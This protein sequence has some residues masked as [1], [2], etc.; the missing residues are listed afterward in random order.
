MFFNY[1]STTNLGDPTI[2][3][4][5]AYFQPTIYTGNGEFKISNYSNVVGIQIQITGD[6]E[7][8]ENYLKD[9][10]ELYYNNNVSFCFVWFLTCFMFSFFHVLY[11]ALFVYILFKKSSFV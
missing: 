5:T 6:F 9:S 2:A 3:D 1:L 8:I 11:L 4:P 10:W 7:I